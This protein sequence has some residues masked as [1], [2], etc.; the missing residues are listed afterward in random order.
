MSNNEP[1]PCFR[2]AWNS[3]RW[4]F[5]DSL[6]WKRLKHVHKFAYVCF[7]HNF[8]CVLGSFS[9]KENDYYRWDPWNTVIDGKYFPYRGCKDDWVSCHCVWILD[10]AHFYNHLL[11]KPSLLFKIRLK[12]KKKKKKLLRTHILLETAPKY[13]FAT[14]AVESV[15]SG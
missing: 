7:P 5:Y 15:S 14:L 2:F 8:S 4:L 3:L 10:I 9:V 12:I 1:R 6:V 11:T 13:N